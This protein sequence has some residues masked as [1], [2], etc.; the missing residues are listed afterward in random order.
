MLRS[1][2]EVLSRDPDR[3]N[4]TL[5]RQGRGPELTGRSQCGCCVIYMTGG[6]LGISRTYRILPKTFHSITIRTSR[7]K[8]TIPLPNEIYTS[9]PQ[10]TDNR[11]LCGTG[12]EAPAGVPQKCHPSAR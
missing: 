8:G 5:T 7:G 2:V 11:L 9:P 6:S 3:G 4:P 1:E 12:R 10:R